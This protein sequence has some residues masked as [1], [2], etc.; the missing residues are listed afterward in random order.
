MSHSKRLATPLIAVVATTTIV[1]GTGLADQMLTSTT[2]SP[3]EASASI[4]QRANETFERFNGTAH[5]RNAGGVLQAYALNGAMDACMDEQGFPG[6]DWSAARNTA[7]RSNATATSVFFAEPLGNA[8]S[9]S[10]SDRAAELRSERRLLTTPAQP[11]EDAAIDLCL[12][13]TPPTSDD[14]A[15]AQSAPPEAQALRAKWWGMLEELDARHGD[16][17]TYNRCMS[18]ADLATVPG[19]VRTPADADTI[20]STLVPSGD[21]IPVDPNLEGASDG[22]QRLIAV[23][24]EIERI[25]WD[26]RREVYNEHLGALESAIVA[27]ETEHQ[28]QIAAAAAAWPRIVEEA[29]QLGYTGQAGPLG[30]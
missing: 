18:E 26:C 9:R 10:L 1:L 5:Q 14:A 20:L 15:D 8:F 3:A 11:A 12:E 17:A 22:W 21:E 23:E 16:V 13:I 24:N 2:S 7:P 25:D 28:A 29:E 4:Q 6:W 19:D 27:F 30:R